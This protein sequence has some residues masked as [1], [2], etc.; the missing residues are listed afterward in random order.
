[1]KRAHY[2]FH[3]CILIA[4]GVCFSKISSHV[5]YSVLNAPV[6]VTID[7]IIAAEYQNTIIDSIKEHIKHDGPSA[8]IQHLCNTYPT[9]ADATV[10]YSI[11]PLKSHCHCSAHIPHC[12]INDTGVMVPHGIILPATVYTPEVLSTLPHIT[13]DPV[14]LTEPKIPDSCITFCTHYKESA[15]NDFQCH[16]RNA[17]TA[18]L[19]PKE[20]SI[21]HL[22]Y[23]GSAVPTEK[24]IPLF[25]TIAN[26]MRV[27]QSAKKEWLIDMR[28]A[29]QIIVS[30]Y[31]EIRS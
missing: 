31:R 8:C 19:T 4:I 17:H 28:F 14:V 13:I 15:C 30:E 9:I 12:V 25:N 23:E 2:Y 21:C 6:T 5:R 27:T 1:M 10:R 11:M 18:I 16:W 20:N 7:E 29:N 3:L 24:D 26:H 22:L